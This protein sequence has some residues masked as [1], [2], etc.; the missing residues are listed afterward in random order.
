MG[1][2]NRRAL[3][4]GQYATQE[5]QIKTLVESLQA[6]VTERVHRQWEAGHRVPMVEWYEGAIGHEPCLIRLF[7]NG[8]RSRID[9]FY[10]GVGGPMGLNHGH[11]T[12]RAGRIDV[13][14]LPGAQ[15][16]SRI[17]LY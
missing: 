3:L 15:G 9:F 8:D 12:I 5:A 17:R 10:G 2:R 11:V 14:L 7:E 13:W 6:H 4:L 1:E 16:S